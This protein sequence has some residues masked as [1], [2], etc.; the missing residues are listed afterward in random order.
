MN[1]ERLKE[2]G[3]ACPILTRYALQL[4]DAF[5]FADRQRLKPVIPLLVGTPRDIETENAR[6][7]FLRFRYV[8]AI[9]PLLLEHVG[10]A[11]MAAKFSAFRNTKQSMAAA[12]QFT[13]ANRATIYAAD[14]TANDN[15]YEY[16]NAYSY[17]NAYADAYADA[18]AYAYAY[19]DAN[20]YAYAD[21]PVSYT[22]L[23]L[24][25]NREG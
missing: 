18:Y 22:H 23:T 1:L 10:L 25:T 21:M 13:L 5:G 19:A 16:A 2:T 14:A 17:A 7:R 4:N 9:Y 20:A 12:S 3:T 8:T 6:I 15:A 11:A 24:P